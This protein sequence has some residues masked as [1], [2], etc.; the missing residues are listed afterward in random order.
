MLETI[1]TTT[2]RTAYTQ[3]HAQSE[4]TST[5]TSSRLQHT[6]T[7]T[8]SHSLTNSLVFVFF[9]LISLIFFLISPA[10][11]VAD[12]LHA[13]GV[14]AEGLPVACTQVGCHVCR[15]GSNE[16]AVLGRCS[17]LK[18]LLAVAKV[19]ANERAAT[20]CLAGL[21]QMAAPGPVARLWRR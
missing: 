13:R 14:A 18:P 4:H 15:G 11:W 12:A 10:R 5:S 16:A 2:V 3:A 9:F 19:T 6:H 8:P 7:H 20:T 21:R 17:R 1:T